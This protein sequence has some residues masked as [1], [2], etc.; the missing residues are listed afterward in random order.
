VSWWRAGVY[1]KHAPNVEPANRNRPPLITLAEQQRR[2]QECAQR[3]KQID[4]KRAACGSGDDYI[5][6][7]RRDM[8]L[9]KEPSSPGTT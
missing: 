8:R 6:N 9:T 1:S 3:E 2:D 7:C 4:S 5:R